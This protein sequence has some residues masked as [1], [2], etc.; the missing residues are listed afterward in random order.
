MVGL[1]EWSVCKLQVSPI[2]PGLVYAQTCADDR[3]QGAT[4][5]VPVA[6]VGRLYWT[7]TGGE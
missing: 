7:T 2:K 6:G 3:P 4:L 5:R 1:D